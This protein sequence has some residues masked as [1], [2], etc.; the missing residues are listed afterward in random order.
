M[1]AAARTSP[2]H[3]PLHRSAVVQRCTY[4]TRRQVSDAPCSKRQHRLSSVDDMSAGR[5]DFLGGCSESTCLCSPPDKQHRT[6]GSPVTRTD[7]HLGSAVGAKARHPA[8]PCINELEE[9][10]WCGYTVS[11]QVCSEECRPSCQN[12]ATTNMAACAVMQ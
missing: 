7:T 5:N 10:L 4:P 2:C 3:A 1:H 6:G 8:L 12:I 11:L 9:C